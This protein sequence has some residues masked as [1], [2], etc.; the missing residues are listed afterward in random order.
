[1]AR[2][3]LLA[4]VVALAALMLTSTASIFIRRGPEQMELVVVELPF[5]RLKG[6]VSV[7]EAIAR[8]RSIR[9]YRD[10][11][12]TLEQLSQILWAAQGI[13]EPE[14]RFRAAPSAGATY[15]LEVYVVV[16]EGGVKGLRAG[17]YRYDPLRHVLVMVKEGNLRVKL[18]EAALGQPWVRSAPVCLVIA[19]DYS[20]T[21]NRYGE[22]GIRYVHME[23]G[24]VGQNVYL[25]ATA[26]GLGT[27]AVGA[28]RDEEVK[29]LLG[30]PEDPLYI[31]PIG[32]PKATYELREEDLRA[33]YERM[34]KG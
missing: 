24:H 26:L 19:A 15:P 6:G 28:F 12:L 3:W 13:T 8:R 17:V 23:A 10:V 29:S 33:F 34:R 7:E 5:P 21:T 18:S 31:M 27:V 22:R 25:E 2:R 16:G 30:I 9:S 32:V 1:M 11:P 20:R 14:R 4:C